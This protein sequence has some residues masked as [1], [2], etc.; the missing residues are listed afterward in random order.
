MEPSFNML[1]ELAP[2]IS[3]RSFANI[4]SIIARFYCGRLRTNGFCSGKCLAACKP[5]LA[6]ML[7]ELEKGEKPLALLTWRAKNE[8]A[9]A[10]EQQR[11]EERHEP[12]KR[13]PVIFD[14]APAPENPFLAFLEK[15][16]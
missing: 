2:Q 8:A 6:V 9:R 13:Q 11:G 4:C 10:I 12:S 7:F 1:R 15:L 5:H 14:Q 16:A 3:G